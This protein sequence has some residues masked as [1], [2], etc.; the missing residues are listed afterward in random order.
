MT[1]DYNKEYK[2]KSRKY[3]Y[4]FDLE[5]R[6]YMMDMFLP[7]IIKGKALEL[8]CYKG[9]FTE[10]LMNYF[11]DIT[12]IDASDELIAHVKNKIKAKINYIT[13]TFE[14]AILNDKYDS[15]FFMHTLE[16]LDDP[17]KVLKQV[18]TWL[19]V[20][21][22]LFLVVPNANA[23]SRQ[24]AVKMGIVDYNSAVIDS[25]LEIGH[26]RTYSFDTLEYDVN[27][28]GLKIVHRGG[29][30]LKPFSSKQFDE[31]LKANIITPEYVKGC[32]ELGMI[33]PDLCASIFVIC[34]KGG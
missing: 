24:I 31:A 34:E 18:N 30:I 26:R 28:A 14:K 13:S 33:Y 21:G 6:N 5:L 16:H 11:D 23:L 25:E 3:A 22:R 17:V 1:R 2:S 20:S 15:I 29:I 12:V 19:S 9:Y 4:D 8:G 7:Y 10:I 32:L 27:R